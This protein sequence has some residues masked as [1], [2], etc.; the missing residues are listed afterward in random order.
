MK[1][2]LWPAVWSALM[3]TTPLMAQEPYP[4]Y[5]YPSGYATEPAYDS[6][7]DT[8]EFNFH[9]NDMM[10]RMPNPMNSMFGSNRRR[11]NA[12]P[13]NRYGPP[14]VYPP[15]YGY[16]VYPAY[17]PPQDAGYARPAPAYAE[18]YGAQPTYPAQPEPSQA[19]AADNAVGYDRA[20]SAAAG[21]LPPPNPASG[22]R[23]NFRPLDNPP[24]AADTASPAPMQEPQ[25][26]LNYEPA[27][28]EQIPPGP[29]DYSAQT[30]QTTQPAT[31]QNTVIHEGHVMKFRPLDKPG[32]TPDLDH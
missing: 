10:N 30:Q 18:P 23:Y 9:P 3:M 27:Y 31:E 12:Y 20:P 15:A 13:E 2:H 24:P 17:Q 21:R 5:G 8:R 7:R 14:P 11:Y 16:P 6:D 29:I 22:E 32:Y 28:T 19:P 4:S 25:A 1:R 26:P